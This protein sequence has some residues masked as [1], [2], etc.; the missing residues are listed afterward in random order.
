MEDEKYAAT[1]LPLYTGFCWGWAAGE[2]GEHPIPGTWPWPWDTSLNIPVLRTQTT[3]ISRDTATRDSNNWGTYKCL[4]DPYSSNELEVWVCSGKWIYWSKSDSRPSAGWGQAF[5]KLA[6]PSLWL[7]FYPRDSLVTD[8][9]AGV[10]CEPRLGAK[11]R[12]GLL[13][14]ILTATC[15]CRRWFPKSSWSQASGVL[16]GLKKSMSYMVSLGVG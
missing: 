4:N 13:P 11:C 2:M 12:E 14:L 9:E 1:E 7:G 5:C 15:N 3:L 10:R 6:I 16:E 8:Q